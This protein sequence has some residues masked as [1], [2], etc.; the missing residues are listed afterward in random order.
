MASK[1]PTH[2]IFQ[3][4]NQFNLGNMLV[5]LVALVGKDTTW[6]LMEKKLTFKGIKNLVLST[7]LIM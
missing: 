7:E 1:T 2:I 3:C 6:D 5:A 4:E